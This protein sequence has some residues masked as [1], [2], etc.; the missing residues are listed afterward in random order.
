MPLTTLDQIAIFIRIE[1]RQI[2][3][4]ETPVLIPI[5]PTWAVGHELEATRRLCLIPQIWVGQ[6]T[7]VFPLR[8]L[9]LTNKFNRL[10]ITTITIRKRKAQTSRIKS[11][12]KTK[13]RLLVK[14][15][16]THM[17]VIKRIVDQSVRV[18]VQRRFGTTLRLLI[19]KRQ[20]LVIDSQRGFSICEIV[21]LE[22]QRVLNLNYVNNLF[23]VF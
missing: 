22:D 4:H 8:I 11:L 15:R 21:K 14:N 13:N 12:Y 23:A 7:W 20:E 5:R 3:N 16:L 1:T 9:T 10:L 19:H 6:K 17:T 2:A 18:E